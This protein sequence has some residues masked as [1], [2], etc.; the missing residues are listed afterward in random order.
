M[1]T[2]LADE[3]QIE[4]STSVWKNQRLIEVNRERLLAEKPSPENP[5]TVPYV[6]L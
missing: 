4:F 3:C 5:G 6:A 2:Y 1:K